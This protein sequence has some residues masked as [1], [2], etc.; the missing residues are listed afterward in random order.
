M[1]TTLTCFSTTSD[2]HLGI[3]GQLCLYVYFCAHSN[4][5]QPVLSLQM[6]SHSE[7]E[8]KAITSLANPWPGGAW[9][10]ER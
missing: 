10:Q 1:Q 2:K 6:E 5:S 4:F 8:G 7:G 9:G 3:S